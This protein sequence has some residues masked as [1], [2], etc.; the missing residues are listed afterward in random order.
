MNHVVRWNVRNRFM[1]A[2][3]LVAV[4]PLVVFATLVYS[5]TAKALHEVEK[6][7]IAAQATGAREALGQRITDERAFLRDYAVWDEFHAAMLEGRRQWIRDNVTGWVPASSSTNLVTVYGPSGRVVARG[8]DGASSSLW[9]SELVRA[10][11]RG[12]IGADLVDI[13]REALRAGRGAHRRADAPVPGGGRARLRRGDHRRGPEGRQSL[14]RG[15]E[16][17]RRL[18]RQRRVGHLRARRWRRSRHARAARPGR[19]SRRHRR[20]LRESARRTHGST[21]CDRRP[22]P[23]VRS[24]SRLRGGARRD[25]HDHHGRLRRRARRRADDGPDH[26]AGRSARR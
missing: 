26:G 21:G 24:P 9:A 20:R 10:A 16:P 1:V 4:V 18:H 5:R 23:G 15:T 19:R 8:G 7:Q 6:S 25:R 17:T 11:R 12:D 22:P 13:G 2:F 3:V 14:H